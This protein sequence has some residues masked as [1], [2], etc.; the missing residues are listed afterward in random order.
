MS[1]FLPTV[2]HYPPASAVMVVCRLLHYDPSHRDDLSTL[3]WPILGEHVQQKERAGASHLG[4]LRN[5]EA[6]AR[7]MLGRALTT[8]TRKVDLLWQEL[9]SC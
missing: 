1:H 5:L 6:L 7:C 9:G 2:S 8:Q 3:T 4:P